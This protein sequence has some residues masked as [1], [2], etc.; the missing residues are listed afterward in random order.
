MISSLFRVL[1]RIFIFAL[2]AICI[3]ISVEYIFPYINDR[4]PAFF[5]LFVVY[6]LF[7]YL[8]IPNLIR[9][10]RVVI[11]PNHIPLYVTTGDGWPSDPVNIAIIARDKAS[12]VAAMKKAGWT[13]AEP[14]NFK[15]ALRALHSFVFNAAYPAAP[16][17]SLYL[18]DRKQDIGF[19]IPTNR[20][21]S[22]RTR[23]HVRFWRLTEPRRATDKHPHL[24][25]WHQKL[26]HFFVGKKEV[27]IGA[28]TEEVIPLDIQWYTGRF[29]HGGSHDSD[30]ERDF[31]IESL[32]K[33]RLVKKQ[34]TTESGD[35]IQF[36]G[37]QFRTIYIT[38][39][40]LK[41]IQL[42]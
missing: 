35:T 17:S 18:F 33:Q 23:H 7:A 26:E 42:K 11:K 29:T 27:W 3:W 34:H 10:F 15:N 8:I 25:F 12:L 21:Q 19:E 38:D 20:A 4:A 36:R 41:V 22:M 16:L 1:W 31:I 6:C 30:R 39:G 40:S 5:A 14:M 2:G 37:Q 24:S 32:K 13:V 28:A 9:L